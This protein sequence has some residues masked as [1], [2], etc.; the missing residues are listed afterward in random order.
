MIV[1]SVAAA[2]LT[3]SD[4]SVGVLNALYFVSAAGG[5]FA[6]GRAMDRF[7]R[8]PG[9]VS[10]YLLLGA[11]GILCAAGIVAS[12][13]ALL[14]GGAVLFGIGFG[15]TKLARAAV[16]D[17]H[18]PEQRGRALGIVLAAGTIGAVGS[19]FLVAFLRSWAGG[20]AIDPD[21]LPWVI[22]PVAAVGAMA[23]ALALR[24]DPRDLAIVSS[25]EQAAGPGR[26][27][28]QLLSVRCCGWPWSSRPSRRWRWW[29]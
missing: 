24:P 22:V 26:T 21:V 29:R 27:P 18:E 14:L 6:F 28:V 23:C 2:D 13:F 7:G 9:L 3:G 17:M 15:G 10:A 8:R 11:A 19:P 5:A 20:E 4:S 12:S 16:A 25:A 1:G